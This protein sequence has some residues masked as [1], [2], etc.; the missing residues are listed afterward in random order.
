MSQTT[1]LPAE[2]YRRLA[3]TLTDRVEA[4]PDSRWENQ[5]P[6]RDWTVRDVL[7]HVIDSETDFLNRADLRIS[8]GPTVDDNPAAAWRHVRNAIQSILDDP[9]TAHREYESGIGKSTVESALSTF[10]AVDL[11]V[12]GWD[13]ANGAGIDDAIP[14]ED[15]EFVHDFVKDKGDMLRSPGGFGPEA[16]VPADSDD[17]TRLLAFLGRTSAQVDPDGQ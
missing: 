11:V 4:V 10:Y 13:I 17:Q 5:S 7:R 16:Q 14:A 12:H 6:C 15:I 3:A 2:R 1:E 9:Q 8:P